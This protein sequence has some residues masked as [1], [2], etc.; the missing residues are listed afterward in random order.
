MDEEQIPINTIAPKFTGNFF[1]GVDYEGN[2]EQFAKEFE[3]DILVVEHMVDEYDLPADLKLSIHSGSDKFSL[4]PYMNRLVDKYD[5]GLHLKT[6]GTTWLEELIGL[7]ISG[8]DGLS[9]VK[10]IYAKAYERYEELIQPYKPVVDISQGELPS[11][12]IF[13]GWNGRI[14]KEK[15]EHNTTNTTFDP[16][17]RQFF[18]C[19]YK[20]AAEAEE[21]FTQ[22]L[23]KNAGM[24]GERVTQNLF[25]KHIAPLFLDSA[26]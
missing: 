18:H 4:Y 9:L 3:Q 25:V 21:T 24:I 23:E 19:S 8:P 12:E 26:R 5:A 1:K 15:L 6:A 22:L 13:N 14:I 17:L 7:S 16:Q 11:P 10:Q 2:V 20:V